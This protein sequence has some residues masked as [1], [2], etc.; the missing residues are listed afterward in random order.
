MEQR[1]KETT[2][3]KFRGSITVATAE[4]MRVLSKQLKAELIDLRRGD[5][6]ING[7]MIAVKHRLL[8]TVNNI[9]NS[10][11]TI[12][13]EDQNEEVSIGNR[14][15]IK[16]FDGKNTEEEKFL[17]MVKCP[18]CSDSLSTS[19]SLGFVLFG[20]KKGEKGT[21]QTAGKNIKFEI[22]EIYEYSKAVKMSE[23]SQI[24][25]VAA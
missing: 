15:R 1:K 7:D 3:K 2:L 20:M 10:N 19:S 17:D 12:L 13:P 21:Y 18:E 14:V 6:G 24:T 16:L 11:K 25:Q 4:C 8:E 5:E 22:L 23:M 9:V